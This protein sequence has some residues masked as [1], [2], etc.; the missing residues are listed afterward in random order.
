MQKDGSSSSNK[1]GKKELCMP[2]I[3][4]QKAVSENEE[5]RE[6]TSSDTEFINDE[7]DGGESTSG[8]DSDTSGSSENEDAEIPPQTNV[9]RKTTENKKRK[10]PAT[11]VKVNEVKKKKVEEKK[12]EPM[13]EAQNGKRKKNWKKEPMMFDD[14][15]VDHN[16]FNS[17]PENV[18]N[19]RIK[20]SSNIIVTCKMVENNDGKNMAYEYAALTIQR[21]TKDGTMFEFVLPLSITM[22]M[23]EAL[24]II[25][26]E[27]PKYFRKSEN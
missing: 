8:S 12:Y 9:K 14:H 2:E 23:T 19:K 26:K 20:I 27:N 4:T 3:Y 13:N 15:N 22:S 7:E 1:K 5:E 24:Q 10:I 21:K 18:V 25:M 6:E 11:K 16:L 17:A